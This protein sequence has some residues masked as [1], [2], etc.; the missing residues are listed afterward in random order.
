MWHVAKL[1][2]FTLELPTLTQ[3]LFFASGRVAQDEAAFLEIGRAALNGANL[4]EDVE[5]FLSSL[6]ARPIPPAERNEP[7]ATPGPTQTPGAAPAAAPQ[8]G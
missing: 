8:T 1:S 2:V 4:P 6:C 3:I 5:S 7:T